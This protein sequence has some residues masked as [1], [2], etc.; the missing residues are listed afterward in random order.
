MSVVYIKCGLM[1]AVWY[2]R[3]DRHTSSVQVVRH[4]HCSAGPLY[5]RGASC[6]CLDLHHPLAQPTRHKQVVSQNKG[7]LKAL[8]PLWRKYHVSVLPPP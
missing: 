3:V 6:A 7:A 1:H 8:H 4:W 2:N 5:P